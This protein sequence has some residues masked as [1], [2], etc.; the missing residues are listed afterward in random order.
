MLITHV[1]KMYVY[2]LVIMRAEKKLLLNMLCSI[3]INAHE[4][5]TSIYIL[6]F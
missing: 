6:R 3:R 1:F 2:F 4:H 5:Q